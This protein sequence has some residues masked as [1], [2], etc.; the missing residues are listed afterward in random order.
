MG[1]DGPPLDVVIRRNDA[2]SVGDA[3]AIP[4]VEELKARDYDMSNLAVIA[5]AGAILSASV[6][7]GIE[8]LLPDVMIIN[9]FGTSE[10]GDLGRAAGPPNQVGLPPRTGFRDRT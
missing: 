1:H 6:Q 7:Q 8:A 2:L 5:S 3:M 10:S 4:L 9:S